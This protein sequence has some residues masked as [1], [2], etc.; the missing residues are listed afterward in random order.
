MLA[1]VTE[2]ARQVM[3]REMGALAMATDEKGTTWRRGVARLRQC[4][5][6]VRNTAVGWKAEPADRKNERCRRVWKRAVLGTGVLGI[7]SSPGTRNRLG[8][9][10]W[11]PSG[12]HPC[13]RARAPP[14]L[15]TRTQI[16]VGEVIVIWCARR[17]IGRWCRG[18][19][20]PTCCHTCRSPR[21]PPWLLRM[22]GLL[23]RA[24]MKCNRQLRRA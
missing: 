7:H 9:A 15:S 16:F 10:T 8:H 4:P 18:A 3:A 24:I 11:A 17:Q 5:N 13:D 6:Y 14:D 19:P 12:R 1:S 22:A 21:R 2:N 20:K 23:D